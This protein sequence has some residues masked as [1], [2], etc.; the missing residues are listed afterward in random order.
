[1]E[2]TFDTTVTTEVNGR[3]LSGLASRSSTMSWRLG[4]TPSPR[5]QAGDAPSLPGGYP[6][7]RAG[8][9]GGGASGGG[10]GRYPDPSRLVYNA[11]LR[12]G[13]GGV[14]QRGAELGEKGGAEGGPEVEVGGYMSDGDILAKNVRPDDVSSG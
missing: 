7:P 13:A 9:G 2:T 4:Q 11:P 10:A 8:G 3:A 5:L 14:G 12:R 1:M 6:Q